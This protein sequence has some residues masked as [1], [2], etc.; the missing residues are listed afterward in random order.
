MKDSDRGGC[1]H[2]ENTRSDRVPTLRP[3]N[4]RDQQWHHAQNEANEVIRIGRN[5]S[6]A[7]SIAHPN[8]ASLGPELARELH[9]QDGVLRRQSDHHQQPDLEVDVAGHTA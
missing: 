3:C 7:A 8:G 6:W 2:A 4:A 9:D 1:E 5:R